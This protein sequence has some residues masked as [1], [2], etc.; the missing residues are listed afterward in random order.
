MTSGPDAF[1]DAP[2]VRID[3]PD[4]IDVAM[5]MAAEAEMLGDGDL[6]AWLAILAPEVR[7]SVPITTTRRRE[8]PPDGPARSFHVNEDRAMLEIRVR[9]LVETN[10]AWSENPV[11]RIRRFVSNI[12]V[13]RGDDALYVS[14]DLLLT[15]IRGDQVTPEISTAERRDRLVRDDAGNLLLAAREVLLDQARLGVPNLPFPF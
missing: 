4:H 11:S 12:R 14:T 9:R 1:R 10:S 15:R 13:R 6:A 2:L 8:D 5:F 3:E 7:Y